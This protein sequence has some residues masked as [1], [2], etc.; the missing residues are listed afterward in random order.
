MV[1]VSL[2]ELSDQPYRFC[3]SPACAAVYYAPA[4]GATL[5][6]DQLRERV[7]QKEPGRNDV[8]VCYCFHHTA[9]IAQSHEVSDRAAVLADITA[10]INADQC[11]CELRNPQGTCCL[12]NV[13]ALMALR[14][15]PKRQ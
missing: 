12:G 2:R 8:L 5:T 13:R 3:A 14:A 15:G 7:Y 6:R 9:G 1:S 10:G 4:N 11:A